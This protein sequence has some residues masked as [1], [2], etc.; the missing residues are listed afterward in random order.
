MA[1]RSLL[2]V[3]STC[4]NLRDERSEREELSLAAVNEIEKEY[5]YIL[6][7]IKYRRQFA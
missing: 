6:L 4:G 5:L 1:L 7:I 2:V 3:Q